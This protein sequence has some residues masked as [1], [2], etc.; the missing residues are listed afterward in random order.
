MKVRLRAFPDTCWFSYG[1]KINIAHNI[2]MCEGCLRGDSWN[3]WIFQ[4]PK[5]QSDT[6]ISRKHDFRGC[7]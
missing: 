5:P 1:P 6:T 7:T 2:F 3:L 4:S